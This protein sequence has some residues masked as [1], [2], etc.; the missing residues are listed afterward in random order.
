MCGQSFT[1]HEAA[2][3]CVVDEVAKDLVSEDGLLT[4][5]RPDRIHTDDRHRNLHLTFTPS[6]LQDAP[7]SAA[8]QWK[9]WDLRVSVQVRPPRLVPSLE[10]QPPISFR[11]SDSPA[12]APG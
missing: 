7:V 9:C 11:N 6:I 1:L 4:Q 8:L 3:D 10:L 12:E 5:A 2:N